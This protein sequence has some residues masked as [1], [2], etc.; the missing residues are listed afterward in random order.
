ML[1]PRS[2]IFKAFDQNMNAHRKFSQ[3]TGGDHNVAQWPEIAILAK[4]FNLE[5]SKKKR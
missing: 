2:P 3:L 1:F 4:N 5:T